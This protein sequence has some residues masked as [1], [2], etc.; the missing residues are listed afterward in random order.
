MLST[1]SYFVCLFWHW[2]LEEELTNEKHL[3]TFVLWV[4]LFSLKIYEECVLVCMCSRLWCTYSSRSKPKCLHTRHTNT[5]N[6]LCET[7]FFSA[8]VVYTIFERMNQID[9]LYNELSDSKE[10]VSE[11]ITK[12][13]ICWYHCTF[14]RLLCVLFSFRFV[15]FFCLR[16]MFVARACIRWKVSTY[17]LLENGEIK[18]RIKLTTWDLKRIWGFDDD[19]LSMKIFHAKH[20]QIVSEYVGLMVRSAIFQLDS[21]DRPRLMTFF[22][23]E[24]NNR[25][26]GHHFIILFSLRNKPWNVSAIDWTIMPR[27]TLLKYSMRNR[28]NLKNYG[29]VAW[30]HWTHLT[31]DMYWHNEIDFCT[32]MCIL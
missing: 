29:V 10:F 31:S 14:D 13:N 30:G 24:A 2:S 11:T 8:S 23:I 4:E 22:A 18:E 32:P 7:F 17:S 21:F 28:C 27:I 19:I 6:L 12:A 15:F 26:I 3:L 16:N 5:P 9:V 20:T 25:I 1:R